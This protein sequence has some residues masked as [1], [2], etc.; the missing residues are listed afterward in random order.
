MLNCENYRVGVLF[1]T[2]IYKLGEPI[3]KAPVTYSR[4]TTCCNSRSEHVGAEKPNLTAWT[5]TRMRLRAIHGKEC[6]SPFVPRHSKIRNSKHIKFQSNSTTLYCSSLAHY[7]N[8]AERSELNDGL[9]CSRAIKRKH[10]FRSRYVM[11]LQ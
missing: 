8:L 9:N 3:S 7:V 10:D 5:G 11:A 4:R 1:Y 6:Y 2:T